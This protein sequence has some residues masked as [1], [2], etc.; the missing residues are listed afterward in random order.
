MP[1]SPIPE[2]IEEIKGGRFIIIVD[3]ENRE[4]EGDLAIAAD[5][6]TPDAINFMARHAR[7]LIC[8]PII[9]SRLDELKVPTMVEHNTAEYRTAF[10]VLRIMS[11]WQSALSSTK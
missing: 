2:I 9:G 3:D 11:F 4:N 5:K 6:V 7:G 1:L 8:F 10:S